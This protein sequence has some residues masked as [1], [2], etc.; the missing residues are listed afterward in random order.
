[1]KPRRIALVLAFCVPLVSTPLVSAPYAAQEST[2]DAHGKV[3]KNLRLTPM[4]KRRLVPVLR[5]EAL[6][7][8][9][10]KN[11]QSLS[12]S[13]KLHRIRAVQNRSDRKLRVILTRSQFK[14]LQ[15]H[16]QQ[17]AQLMWA[18]MQAQKRQGGAARSAT[19]P[20]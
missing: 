8:Q 9:G 7:V 14:Q 10:I 3:I 20:R 12:R 2:G 4:Q 13:Q 17:R 5:A 11:D 15:A 16:R 18:A 1:M 6:K 19:P